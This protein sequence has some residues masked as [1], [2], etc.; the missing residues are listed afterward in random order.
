[1]LPRTPI[2]FGKKPGEIQDRANVQRTFSDIQFEQNIPGKELSGTTPA[3][4]DTEF[5]VLHNLNYVPK[6][7]M[8]F[9]LDAAARIYK[10]AT[11]WTKTTAYLKCDVGNV[12]YTIFIF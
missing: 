4:A 12:A 9:G 6:R 7:I 3:V 8:T 1:M 2:P 10:G 5:A 11:P